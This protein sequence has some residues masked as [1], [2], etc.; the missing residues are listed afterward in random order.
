VKRREGPGPN[1]LREEDLNVETHHGETPDGMLPAIEPS[2]DPRCSTGEMA[3]LALVEREE[4]A[5]RGG[6]GIR[7]TSLDRDNLRRVVIAT[8]TR[9][10]EERV[11]SSTGGENRENVL[12]PT[13]DES[14]PETD[15]A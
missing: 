15:Q 12:D 8:T 11:D 10:A 4:L 14:G 3:P 5:P 1:K 9:P 2:H 6:E 7:R 13:Q